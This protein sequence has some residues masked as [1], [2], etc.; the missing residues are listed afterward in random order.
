MASSYLLPAF[1][2]AH[3]AFCAML[4]RLRATA[5]IVW[6]RLISRAW[7]RPLRLVPLWLRLGGRARRGVAERFARLAWRRL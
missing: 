5:D 2:F 6:P 4:I 7:H 1:T 3:R